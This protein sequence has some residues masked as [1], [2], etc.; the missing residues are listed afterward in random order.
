MMTQIHPTALRVLQTAAFA[1]ALLL[2]SPLAGLIDNTMRNQ[3]A[4]EK[5][6]LEITF[7]DEGNRT[8]VF[9]S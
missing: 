9:K 1:T 3:S 4:V 5:G 2:S 6:D 8:V 7:A